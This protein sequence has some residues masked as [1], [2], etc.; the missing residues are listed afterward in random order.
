MIPK[1]EGPRIF[2]SSG[3]DNKSLN[4]RVGGTNSGGHKHHKSCS[5]TINP[6]PTPS[7]TPP[8][9]TC[10]LLGRDRFNASKVLRTFNFS[11]DCSKCKR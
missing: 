2:W 4:N 9:C 6:I 5:T 3:Q 8:S 7:S 10:E 1:R 11:N